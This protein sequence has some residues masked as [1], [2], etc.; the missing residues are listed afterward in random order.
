MDK[1]I[2]KSIV[3]EKWNPIA[4]PAKYNEFIKSYFSDK[5]EDF[6][7]SFLNNIN[8]DTEISPEYKESLEFFLKEKSWDFL[9]ISIDKISIYDIR[10]TLS[11]ESQKI[12]WKK[13][14]IKNLFLSKYPKISS[15][16]NTKILPELNK[17]NLSSLQSLLLSEEKRDTFLETILWKD[18]DLLFSENIN[19]FDELSIL[20]KDEKRINELDL[21]YNW[22]IKI[23][24]NYLNDENVLTNKD[25]NFKT[26]L[27]EL[28]ETDIFDNKYKK[29]LI[30]NYFPNISLKELSEILL[31]D[32]D[33]I[34]SE[35]IKYINNNFDSKYINHVWLDFLLKSLN[36]NDITLSVSDFLS[37]DKISLFIKKFW[38]QL[39]DNISKSYN[40]ISSKINEKLKEE[41]PFNFKILEKELEK[42]NKNSSIENLNKFKKWNI[43]ELKIKKDNWIVENSFLKIKSLDDD[44][45]EILLDEI[46]TNNVIN[47]SLDN[48]WKTISYLEFLN[49]S[50]KENIS[51][52]FHTIDD[53]KNKILKEDIITSDL[54]QYTLDDLKNEDNKSLYKEKYFKYKENQLKELKEKQSLWTADQ[55]DLNN[56]DKLELEINSQNISDEKLLEYLNFDSLISKLD[57]IDKDWKELWLEAWLLLEASDWWV[58]KIKSVDKEDWKIIVETLWQEIEFDYESFYQTFKKHKTQRA[59][60]IDNFN[61]L[62][63]IFKKSDHNN[64]SKIGFEDWKIVNKDTDNKEKNKVIDYFISETEDDIVK[65]HSI[66]WDQITVSFWERKAKN[67]LNKKDSLYDPNSEDEVLFIEW[68]QEF[69]YSLNEFKKSILWDSQYNFKP[70]W[71]TWKKI[72]NT[73]ESSWNKFKWSLISRLFNRAS[74][75]DLLSWWKM[76]LSSIEDTLKRWNDLKAAKLALSMWK[77]LPEE[78]RSELKIKVEREEWE[79][80][81]KALDWLWKVDSWIAVSRIKWWLENKDTPEYKKEAWL[82]FMLSKYGHLTAKDALYEFRWKYFWYEA[83]WWKVGDNFFNEKKK[84]CLEWDITFSEEYLMHMLLKKQCWWKWFNGIIRR[85]RLHKEYE[86]KWAAWIR[87]EFEKWYN[88]ASRKRKASDML[89]WGMGEALWGTT[90]NAIGWFKKSIE[91]WW[92]V[93]DMSEWFFTL[94]YSWACYDL[95]Q[96]TYLNIRDLWGSGMPIIMTKFFSTVPEMKSFNNAVLEVSKEIQ[97]SYGDKFPNIAKDALALY[98]DAKNKKWSEENR[99]KRAQNFWKEYSKPLSNALNMLNIKDWE[100]SKT[101][102][103]VFLKKDENPVLW[104][105]YSKVREYTAEGGTFKSDYMWDACWDGWISWLDVNKVFLKFLQVDQAWGLREKDA[106]PLVWKRISEDIKSTK[107]KTFSDNIAEDVIFKKEYLLQTIR[108]IVAAINELSWWREWYSSWYNS[109]S[110]ETWVDFKNWWLDLSKFNDKSPSMILE[111]K[112]DKLLYEVVDNILSWRN[113]FDESKSKIDSVFDD[114]K[115]SVNTQIK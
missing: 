69:T 48:E 29:K 81:D 114:I 109:L 92:T 41:G 75:A 43:L 23:I 18:S 15:V 88:D 42:N 71:S 6:Q 61:S 68:A 62:I 57:E 54:Q 66:V 32:K 74:F 60:K 4:G 70:S 20:S 90:T 93:E 33:F 34:K 31:F 64:W 113:L 83:F 50:K 77:F 40:I 26:A 3:D 80:M 99:L 104:E 16:Y 106:W 25:S 91:R 2:N 112:S 96:K 100:F 103:I 56:I 108:E 13:A 46:W 51:I 102:K 53:I 17:N 44:K 72:K 19:I 110:T 39:S 78:L 105:Y 86:W 95:D 63:D 30:I 45:K 8:S 73:E 12:N 14:S 28:L 22:E 76:L 27:F 49:L 115:S 67:A 37:D 97:K 101:D 5:D 7:V 38:Y 89:K 21:K 47:L 84:E 36:D 24:L 111:W 98:N 55:I 9:W 10:K 35:K 107:D 59:K 58:H 85:S 87:E 94:L 82:M 52:G 11:Q 65:V 1:N 79:S